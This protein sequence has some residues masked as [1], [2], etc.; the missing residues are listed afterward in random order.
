MLLDA[1]SIATKDEEHAVS[2]VIDGPSNPN[3]YD[4][5]VLMANFLSQYIDWG[6]SIRGAWIKPDYVDTF[7]W[8]VDFVEG[9]EC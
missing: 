2:I 7:Q 1:I 9:K 8:L 4:I 5:N 3:E 6:T